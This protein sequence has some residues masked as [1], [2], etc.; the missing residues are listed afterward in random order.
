MLKSGHMA[1]RQLPWKRIRIDGTTGV[2]FSYRVFEHADLS[3]AL[4]L[5]RAFEIKTAHKP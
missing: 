4:R 2:R 1:L 5:Q 3:T